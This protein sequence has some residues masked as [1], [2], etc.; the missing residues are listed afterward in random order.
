[1]N[2]L[3]IVSDR[4]GLL[5]VFVIM[6]IVSYLAAEIFYRT[7]KDQAL[8]L[9]EKLDSGRKTLINII[10]NN[11][12]KP[13]GILRAI[14]VIFLINLVGG[15]F[16]WSTIGGLFIVLP[17]I[18]YILIGFLVNLV[19]KRYPER[20]DWLVIPNIIF[21]VA[22]FMV[23]ALGSIHI[24]LSILGR[25]DILLAVSQWIMLFIQLVIPLQIIAAIFEGLL[26]YRI[27]FI[28]KHPWPHG[29]SEMK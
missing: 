17:F 1:M 4:I 8:N 29:I 2:A 15:A 27:H 16:F 18:H 19:L 6:F 5:L 3:G 22:A 9:G 28:R 23:A 7:R 13:Y 21:E 12:N 11:M 24:S 25:G 20:R 10:Y 14:F 26:L